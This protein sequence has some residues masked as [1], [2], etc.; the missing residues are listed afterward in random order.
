MFAKKLFGSGY[1]YRIMTVFDAIQLDQH[2]K[3]VNEETEKFWKEEHERR[4]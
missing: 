4:M 3:A 2:E 1:T